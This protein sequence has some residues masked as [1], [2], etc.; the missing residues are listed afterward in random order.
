MTSDDR[1]WLGD[2]FL[3]ACGGDVGLSEIENERIYKLNMNPAVYFSR[4]KAN[5]FEI[6]VVTA[7]EEIVRQHSVFEEAARVFI[8][9]KL[10]AC[11]NYKIGGPVFFFRDVD[12]F[13]SNLPDNSWDLQF[14]NIISAKYQG[15]CLIVT[16]EGTSPVAVEDLD[17]E[18]G[19]QWY[20][21]VAEE[22][23]DL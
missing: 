17:I 13:S 3:A 5:G 10:T 22:W 16:F 4:T 18:T 23:V 15:F 9:K 21:E 20:D 19:E 14:N 7:A 11:A 6:D 12:F 2:Y 1:D 8:K